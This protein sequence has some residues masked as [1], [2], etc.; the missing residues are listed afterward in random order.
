MGVRLLIVR[1][2]PGT[3]GESKRSVHLIDCPDDGPVPQRL[4]ARCGASFG[5]GELELLDTVR[6]MP[7]ESCLRHTPPAP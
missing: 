6:G 7:C 1:P 2:R 3:V 4:Y 5:A